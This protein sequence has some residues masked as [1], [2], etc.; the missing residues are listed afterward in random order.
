MFI[1]TARRSARRHEPSEAGLVG[2]L[3]VEELLLKG[4]GS[5]W[6]QAPPCRGRDRPSLQMHPRP[7]PPSRSAPRKDAGEAAGRAAATLE[8]DGY[9]G[10]AGVAG[11]RA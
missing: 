11:D 5:D 4:G 1:K 8:T 9:R 7:Q 3:D 2:S 10:W 6:G